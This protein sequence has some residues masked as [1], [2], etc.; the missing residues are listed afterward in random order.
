MPLHLTPKADL[1]VMYDA[2]TIRLAEL[3]NT[4]NFTK[5]QFLEFCRETPSVGF[6]MDD[7]AFGGAI[8][9]DHQIHFAVMPEF[10][11]RWG[12]L[13]RPMW[14]WMFSIEDD[15]RAYV[16]KNNPKCLNFMSRQWPTDGE[17]DTF[18]FFR[19]TRSGLDKTRLPRKQTTAPMTML[20]SV[21]A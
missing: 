17:D 8:F 19:L 2:E 21:L 15:V 20:E 11:G 14:E 16:E 3:G 4:I 5:E 10:H 12:R 7:V 1:G 18:I 6:S 13:V 9:H